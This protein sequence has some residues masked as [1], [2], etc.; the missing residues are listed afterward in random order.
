MSRPQDRDDY[1]G[2]LARVAGIQ[3]QL[4]E[5]DRRILA[6]KDKPAR[7]L[8]SA[9]NCLKC[10]RCSGEKPCN[11]GLPVRLGRRAAKLAVD[12]RLAREDLHASYLDG[13]GD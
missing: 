2:N 4:R 9:G 10:R 1:T 6:I 12:L 13:E 8:P 7:A 11:D 3:E 5:L